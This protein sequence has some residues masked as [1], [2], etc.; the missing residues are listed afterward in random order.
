MN[1]PL[2]LT[3]AL[4]FALGCGSPAAPTPAPVAPPSA[5]AVVAAAPETSSG[6]SA[7]DAVPAAPMT[8]VDLLHAVPARVA[9]SSAYHDDASQIARI[10]D[11]D[12][13]T[14]WNSRSG[15]LVGAWIEVELPAEA[16]V[17]AIAMTVGFTRT[18]DRSDLFVGNHRVSR[19]RLSRVEAAGEVDVL[20]EHDLDTSS[21][22]LVEIPVNERGGTLRIEVLTTVPGTHADWR[23]ICISEIRALGTAAGA[24]EGALVPTVVVGRA[25]TEGSTAGSE[26]DEEDA[27]DAE[28]AA[29]DAEELAQD[30][31][32]ACSALL[33]QWESY[34]SGLTR[35]IDEG[36]TSDWERDRVEQAGQRHRAL[37]DHAAVLFAEVSPEAASDATTRAGRT[38]S[39]YS[40]RSED[41]EALVR[42]C[43]ASM[44][45]YP[46]EACG[47]SEARAYARLHEVVGDAMSATFTAETIVQDRRDLDGMLLRGEALERARASLAAIT[48]FNHWLEHIHAEDWEELRHRQRATLLAGDVSTASMGS[49]WDVLRADVERAE[50][51]CGSAGR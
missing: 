36:S 5:P 21:R 42:G 29:L 12:L 49:A 9:V 35:S 4:V 20:G 40:Q 25:A 19:V 27:E 38:Y 51:A 28:L 2:A 31:D 8:E 44:A 13:T 32:E 3:L 7:P 16:N 30:A 41:F 50:T 22:E 18:T 37:F 45:R 26:Q 39:F 34:A 23:E 24:S 14:A 48:A 47:W 43:D 33:D 17:R 15:D 46:S 6:V 1:P 11:G 10:A